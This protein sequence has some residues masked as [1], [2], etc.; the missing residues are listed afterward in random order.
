MSYIGNLPPDIGAYDVESFDG[1]GTSF[2][3]K[4]AATV[5][6]VLLFIDGVRQTPTDAYTVSGVT[7]T[8][9]ATTPSGTD[10]VTV[11]FMGDVVDI[12]A[13][14]ADTVSTA[15]IQDDAVTTAKINDDAVTAAKLAN[16]INT[17]IAANTAKVTN[18]THTGDVTGATALTIAA[19]AVDIAMLSATGTASASTFLR[20]DNAWAAAGGDNTPAFQAYL[21]A[22]QSLAYD[23]G[24]KVTFDTEDFDTDG[25]YDNS[26]NYRFTVPAGEGGKYFVYYKCLIE[27]PG[28]SSHI[29]SYSYVQVNGSNYFWMAMDFSSNY[30]KQAAYTNSGIVTLAAA[31]YV[32][33]TAYIESTPTSASS[34]KSYAR[35]AL[36]GAYKLIGL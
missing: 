11:M 10:N 28:N 7:L 21:S 8:T 1:G 5:S 3:L 27:G 15:K 13:P 9:T 6:S 16:S 30:G 18:A 31:D 29:K 17:E 14:S 25:A 20:G 34:I 2:T 4:R 22:S 12:G 26:T 32:E 33:C 24:T 35:A 23:T 19:D 36:F